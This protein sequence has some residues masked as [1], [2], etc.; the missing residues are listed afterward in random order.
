MNP[1]ER[2]YFEFDEFR[3]DVEERRLTRAGKTVALTSRDLDILLVLVER[4]GQTVEKEELMEAVWRDTFVEEGNLSRHVSTLRKL[5]NDDPKGQRF[6]KT[7]PKR[8]YRFTADVRESIV[9]NEEIALETIERSRLTVTEETTE[10]SRP[11]VRSLVALAVFLMLSGTLVAFLWGIGS[12]PPRT[13]RI[14]TLAVIPFRNLRPDPE[15]DFLSYAL[16][17]S[18]TGRLGY[19]RK[20]IVR[21]TSA[22]EKFRTASSA[23]TATGLNVQTLLMGS[24]VKEGDNLRITVE[25]IDT[26]ENRIIWQEAFDLPYDKLA[27]VQ[28]RVASD[29]VRGLSLNLS[30]AEASHIKGYTPHP[31]AYEYDLRGLAI[32][33]TSDYRTALGMYE[34]AIDID[35]NFALAW[36]HVAEV[37]YFY[38]NDKESGSQFRDKANLAL[39]RALELEPDQIE[40]RLTSAFQ[41]VDNEGRIEEAIPILRGII[42]TNENNAFAHWFLSQAYRYGGMLDESIAEAERA[43]QIDPDVM[44]D[45]SFNTLLYAGQFE[46]FLSSMAL[47]PEGART[48][49]YRGL[50]YLYLGNRDQAARQFDSAYKLDSTYP[51]AIIGKAMSCSLNGQKSEGE[52]LLREFERDHQ[53]T[54][55]EMLYKVAQGYA[56]LDARSDAL[57]LLKRAIDQNFICYPYFDNDPLLVNLREEPAFA[58]ILAIASQRHSDFKRKL[59]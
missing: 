10:R 55:G 50:G 43:L 58:E 16:A 42:E 6:I 30:K 39:N 59:F 14:R 19:V 25:L 20:L 23:E 46:R 3:I 57:R 4:A 2:H 49:F 34:K 53:L 26:V 21:P 44:R 15:S 37:C 35:P 12:A 47:K 48:N 33:K 29:V 56:A 18:I 1:A 54:D 22:G 11:S 41:M 8:G 9:S 24:Y 40:A 7:V 13:D 32:S 28:E 5:L 51:H 52:R 27:T 31:T 36:T 38:A 17:Q 45:T